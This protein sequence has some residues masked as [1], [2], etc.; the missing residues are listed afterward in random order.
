LPAA[1]LVPLTSHEIYGGHH[2]HRV[3]QETVLVRDRGELERTLDLLWSP[4][5]VIS[6]GVAMTGPGLL[7]GDGQQL[8]A[9]VLGRLGFDY[10]AHLG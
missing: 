10:D 8:A 1:D 2:T 5:A 6:E 3:W 9:E 4:E 7:A